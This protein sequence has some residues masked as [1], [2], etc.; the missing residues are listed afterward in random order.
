MSRGKAA[1]KPPAAGDHRPWPRPAGPWVMRQVWSD[2]LFA[3]WRVEPAGLRALLPAG[4]E[5]DL[6][7]GAAWLAITPL[8]LSGVRARWTPLLPGTS[9]FLELNVRTYVTAG[10]KPGVWF[11]SLDASSALAVEGAR[12]LY[13]LPYF[14]A[15]M[16]SRR[17]GD[18]IVFTSERDDPRAAPASV[19]ARYAPE[20]EAAPATAGSLKRFLVERYCLY[21][22]GG[23][24]RLFRSEIDH[25]PWLLHPAR[26]EIACEG[27]LPAGTRL[28]DERPLFHVSR[29]L[30]VRV[31]RLRGPL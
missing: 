15:R 25:A 10:D 23:R 6:H 4:L 18:E 2:V 11:F 9:R 22:A 30:E 26:A 1:A 12:G 24:G 19:H 5:L 3:H 13:Q 16:S 14:R 20:G 27:L 28:V 21:A 31:W 17:E 8:H 29:R 7:E